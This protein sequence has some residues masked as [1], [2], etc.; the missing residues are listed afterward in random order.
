MSKRALIRC[1]LSLVL[2][3]YLVIAVTVSRRA[4]A[5]S[6]LQGVDI[7]V[8][9]SLNSGFITA[10][11]VNTAAGDLLSLLDTLRRGQVNTL[12][13]ENRLR[14]LQNIEKARCVILNNGVLRID[15]VPM[16]PVARVFPDNAPSYYVNAEGKR[17]PATS[18]AR[19]DV[20][21]IAGHIGDNTDIKAMLPMLQAIHDDPQLDAWASSLT[22][23][24]RG[25]IIVIPAVLGH[26]VVMGDT[27]DISSKFARIKRFYR[28]IMPV[29]GWNYYDTISVKWQGRVVATRRLKKSRDNTP[30]TQLDGLID[31]T[32]D[33]GIML[34]TAPDNP[35]TDQSSLPPDAPTAPAATTQGENKK[36]SP[37]P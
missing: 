32:L 16:I 24:R 23:G 19:I 35:A 21:A 11:D 10:S 12:D 15:V 18:A 3:A 9:D 25:D 36:K 31:E 17:I 30:L 27:S 37:T 4:Q 13:I 5:A 34:A 14:A 1:L 33:D 22:I 6:T 28:E 29:K 7:V 8:S 20:P 26:V 2:V